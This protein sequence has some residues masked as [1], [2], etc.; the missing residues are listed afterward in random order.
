ML[1]VLHAGR[2]AKR[3]GDKKQGDAES[4]GATMG[5]LK[6]IF[7]EAKVPAPLATVVTRW[8]EGVLP[9]GLLSRVPRRVDARLRRDG[10][11]AM[12][13]FS[14]VGGRGDVPRAP[15]HR[16]RRIHQRDARGG[17]SRL[18][19]PPPP[20]GGLE[21]CGRPPLAASAQFWVRVGWGRGSGRWGGR[22]GFGAGTAFHLQTT[23]SVVRKRTIRDS[24]RHALE[25]T[26]R[27]SLTLAR[28][29]FA[30]RRVSSLI[31]LVVVVALGA[32]E[33]RLA[34]ARGHRRG[35]RPP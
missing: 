7:G 18:P 20:G 12:G 29:R 31:D 6:S 30:R 28:R 26:V 21:R 34:K 8:H 27:A 2:A 16:R 33:R 4:V 13:R 35:P 25:Y 14:A 5:A 9:R 3:P 32:R 19:P 1:L 17:A 11:S 24:H 10:C 22:D 23:L 15:R